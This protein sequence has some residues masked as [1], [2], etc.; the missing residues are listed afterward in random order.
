MEVTDV[1]AL[2]ATFQDP[3][4]DWRPSID[5][6]PPPP[7]PPRADREPALPT[8]THTPPPSPPPPPIPLRLPPTPPPAPPP[9]PPAER[10][11]LPPT[12]RDPD[13]AKR[14]VCAICGTSV[15]QDD[16]DAHMEQT[17][18]APHKCEYCDRRFASPTSR[19]RHATYAHAR[20]DRLRSYACPV[21]DCGQVFS[22]S[23]YV[24]MH[25]LTKHAEHTATLLYPCIPCQ[26]VFQSESGRSAHYTTKRHARIAGLEDWP[27]PF[28]CEYCP[29]R[30]YRSFPALQRHL[31][32][33]H[34]TD[35]IPAPRRSVLYNNVTEPVQMSD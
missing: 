22:G 30:R 15:L 8:T 28:Q 1:G 4:S 2:L 31:R 5:P 19:E 21:A 9:P 6:P 26:L 23:S 35:G 11:V 20:R 16:M 32:E 7:S 27:A 29:T 18:P 10:Y 24:S 25:V 13:W 3:W 34:E 17:H 14:V 33:Q 12:K